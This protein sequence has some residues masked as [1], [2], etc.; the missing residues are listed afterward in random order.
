[1]RDERLTPLQPDEETKPYKPIPDAIYSSETI[2]SDWGRDNSPSRGFDAVVVPDDEL[3]HGD[4]YEEVEN[5]L[6]R[7]VHDYK[8][9]TSEETEK[10]ERSEKQLGFLARVADGLGTFHTAYSHARGVKPM[11]M[12]KMSAK[13][14][15]RYERAKAA[16]EA[17][18]DRYFNYA[19]KLGQIRENED[20]DRRAFEEHK[21][22]IGLAAA[23][24]K[25][26][27]EEHKWREELQPDKRREQKNKADGAGY[28]AITKKVK[29]EWAPK[30]EEQE[31]ENL[32]KK[33]VLLGAQTNN[34]NAGAA[35]HNRSNPTE[36]RAYDANGNARYFSS[37]SAALDFARQEGTIGNASTSSSSRSVGNDGVT[38]T[39]KTTDKHFAAKPAKK[40]G[41][42]KK[43]WASG[44]KL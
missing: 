22:R 6:N 18:K 14:T 5:F 12:P 35:A 34:A 26:E 3:F 41:G 2:K 32:K 1:M 38:K 10:R 24:D 19:F 11:D 21:Q 42:A 17:D 44:L 9:E 36:F 7:Q 15:E 30:K 16:R 28:D 31:Y 29:S 8:P 43:G 37:E 40:N 39:T 4:N 27:Q 13:A 20:K 23:K 25:R 33:G